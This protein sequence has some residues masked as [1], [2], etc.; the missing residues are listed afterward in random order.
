MQIANRF[1]SSGV[2]VDENKKQSRMMIEYKRI[3][4]REGVRGLYRY[5]TC[6][7]VIDYF[8]RGLVPELLKVIPVVAISFSMY[9][10]LKG[11]DELH[12][13]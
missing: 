1:P 3:L 7:Y 9:E 13:P 11:S 4:N 5:Y 2:D 12:Y 8:T 10:Y 6:S